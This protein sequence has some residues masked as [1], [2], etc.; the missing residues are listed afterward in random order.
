[1]Q[2]DTTSKDLNKTGIVKTPKTFQL[3][4][5]EN[6]KTGQKIEPKVKKQ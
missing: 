2:A 1:L 3:H 5:Y 4:W 6:I